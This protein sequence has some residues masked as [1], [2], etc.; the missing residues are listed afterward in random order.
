M[1]KERIYSIRQAEGQGLIDFDDKNYY[2]SDS[3]IHELFLDEISQILEAQREILPKILT[4]LADALKE[5][6]TSGDND[7]TA[8]RL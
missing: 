2:L 6:D 7:E 4:Y 5:L 8:T 1:N 3:D